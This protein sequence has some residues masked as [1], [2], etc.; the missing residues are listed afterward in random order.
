MPQA[1]CQVYANF[2]Y[3]LGL[4]LFDLST[5]ALYMQ[6]HSSSYT[7]DPLADAFEDDLASEVAGPGY[8]A[9]G[10]ELVDVD[11][12]LITAANAPQWSP[13]S[14]YK[15]GQLV[16]KQSTNGHI[17]RCILQGVS[18]STEPSW[19]VTPGRDIA[20]G[21]VLWEEA[22]SAYAKLSFDAPLWTPATLTAR[23][24]VLIDKEPGAAATNPLICY[25][26]FG[27]DRSSADSDFTLTP[28]TSAAVYL[29]VA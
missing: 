28:D 15:V 17:Y 21:S 6:L 18:G 16:R 23:F 27:A 29:R 2:A 22:G 13:A 14:T 3:N 8:T 11:W 12:A 9:G 24:A 5:D 1:S 10:Q 20:D 19:P 25:W 7:P 4:Q 26:D